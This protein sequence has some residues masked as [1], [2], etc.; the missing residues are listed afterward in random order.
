MKEGERILVTA[1]ICGFRFEKSCKVKIR[2]DGLS[3]GKRVRVSPNFKAHVNF[4]SSPYMPANAAGASTTCSGSQL[5]GS[6]GRDGQP[7]PSILAQQVAEQAEQPL[8]QAPLRLDL[9]AVLVVC[10]GGPRLAASE[11][12]WR[13]IA[14]VERRC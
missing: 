11:S 2:C 10:V 7:M 1:V 3:D 8:R 14:G 6:V 4:Q 5:L 13:L 12:E 9:I